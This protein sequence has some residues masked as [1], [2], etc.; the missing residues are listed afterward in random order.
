M[1]RIDIRT[2]LD[3]WCSVNGLSTPTAMTELGCKGR[4]PAYA[5]TTAETYHISPHRSR[6][7]PSRRY[8]SA[9]MEE[10]LRRDFTSLTLS[11][12]SDCHT[13]MSSFDERPDLAPYRA[14]LSKIK[15]QLT[16]A[17]SSAASSKRGFLDTIDPITGDVGV[18]T[19][20]IALQRAWKS[21]SRF[22]DL[23][24]ERRDYEVALAPNAVAF[25]SAGKTYESGRRNRLEFGRVRNHVHESVECRGLGSILA[26]AHPE[27]WWGG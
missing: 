17:K 24:A 19:A 18:L 9:L 1:Y 10:S 22:A 13:A 6:L 11:G 4:R 27:Q 21:Y 7:H 20:G 25:E 12:T 26:A 3:K 8:H 16:R 14:E 5:W 2:S 15:T 23:L